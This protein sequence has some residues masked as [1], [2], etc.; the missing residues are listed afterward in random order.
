MGSPIL[1][2]EHA[3]WLCPDDGSALS[4]TYPDADGMLA[5]ICD[6]CAREWDRTNEDEHLSIHD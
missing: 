6:I 3:V 2:P 4:L 1:D 5:F